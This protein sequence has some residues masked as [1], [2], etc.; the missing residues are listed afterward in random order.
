[1]RT[2][3][4]MVNFFYS[5][6]GVGHDSHSHNSSIITIVSSDQITW[7]HKH[8]IKSLRRKVVGQT[9]LKAETWPHLWQLSCSTTDTDHSGAEG[10]ILFADKST[11]LHSF[12]HLDVVRWFHIGTFLKKNA[13][14][15]L[16]LVVFMFPPYSFRSPL[17]LSTGIMTPY[18]LTD[19]L[20]VPL[21]L[22]I[23]SVYSV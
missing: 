13:E 19:L 21:T 5:S 16:S 11:N 18:F 2:S 4:K 22:S 15:C 23:R 12:S 8:S 6:S 9:G 10:T 20:P 1:M 14:K 7:S 3:A 17:Y